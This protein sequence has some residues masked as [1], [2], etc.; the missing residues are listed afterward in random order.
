[1]VG[2]V[3]NRLTMKETFIDRPTVCHGVTLRT[4]GE[5]SAK[6]TVVAVWVVVWLMG[7]GGGCGRWVWA[8]GGG[9][10]LAGGW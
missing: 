5:A 10:G 8:V 2:G 3:P 1:M 9:G 7:V 4:R 6:H